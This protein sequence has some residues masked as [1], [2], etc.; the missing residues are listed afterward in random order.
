MY[1]LREDNTIYTNSQKY[2][3]LEEKRI[4]FIPMCVCIAHTEV[5]KRRDKML[6]H[7]NFFAIN[8]RA[9]MVLLKIFSLRNFYMIIEYADN[10]PL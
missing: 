5:W 3:H 2:K 8:T 6:K 1:S 7:V 10:F 9:K 4:N